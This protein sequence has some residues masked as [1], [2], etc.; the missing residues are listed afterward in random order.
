MIR[1]QY[2]SVNQGQNARWYPVRLKIAQ[3]SLHGSAPMFLTVPH[4]KK[5][6]LKLNLKQGK[7]LLIKSTCVHIHLQ[8]HIFL[9]QTVTWILVSI[10]SISVLCK[11]LQKNRMHEVLGFSKIHGKTPTELQLSSFLHSTSSQCVFLFIFLFQDFPLM[12][13]TQEK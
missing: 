2:L 8:T 1:T 6:V 13:L 4:V 5:R 7:D 12:I 10:V 9:T 3:T 11:H